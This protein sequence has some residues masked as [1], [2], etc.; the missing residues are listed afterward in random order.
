MRP[1]TPGLLPL[2]TNVPALEAERCRLE[3]V[4]DQ[5]HEPAHRRVPAMERRRVIVRLDELAAERQE[6]AA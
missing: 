1:K 3:R 5:L 4:L 6:L 2:P